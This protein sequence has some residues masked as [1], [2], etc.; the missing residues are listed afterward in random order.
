VEGVNASMGEYRSTSG[1]G[2]MGNVG[3]GEYYNQ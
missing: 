1:R 2:G 3:L